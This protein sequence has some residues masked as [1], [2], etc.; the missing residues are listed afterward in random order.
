MRRHRATLCGPS[1]HSSSTTDLPGTPCAVSR[2]RTTS[3]AR[4]APL[5]P[6]FLWFLAGIVASLA[7]IAVFARAR[8]RELHERTD[9]SLSAP[10]ALDPG[11]EPIAAPRVESPSAVRPDRESIGTLTAEERTELD[12]ARRILNDTVRDLEALAGGLGREL[13]GLS[14]AIEGHTLHLLEADPAR[15]RSERASRDSLANSLRRLRTFSEK[16]LCFAHVDEVVGR[17]V[18]VR[19]LLDAVARD[20]SALGTRLR[21]ETDAA[22]FLPAVRGDQRC[23]HNAILFLAETLV[24]LER[25]ATRVSLTA[26]AEVY[27][28]SE[29][30]VSIEIAVESDGIDH[31]AEPNERIVHLGYV[32]ARNLIEAMSGHLAFDGVEGLTQWSFVS[33]PVYDSEESDETSTTTELA[34]IVTTEPRHDFGGVLILEGDPELRE[35]VAHELRVQG[36]NIVSCVDGAAARSLIDATPERFEVAILAEDSRVENLET[37]V[38]HACAKI[39]GVRILVLGTMRRIPA[40][41]VPPATTLLAL[42]KPFGVLELRAALGELLG[43]PLIESEPLL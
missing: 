28:E 5:M 15:T 40:G 26:R 41:V 35:M 6:E 14:S 33:L 19:P 32:A 23:L 4:V 39:P 43:N 13:A 22:E 10:P 25:R 3:I 9:A 18:E 20:I 11:A 34:S 8:T 42:H 27:D 36:R 30:R 31:E 17:R 38:R 37:V 24:S 2:G 1:R 16:F 12:L 7:A 21:V 29:T